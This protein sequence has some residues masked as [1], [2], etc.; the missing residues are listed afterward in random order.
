MRGDVTHH[1]VD[2]SLGLPVK[3]ALAY[4]IEVS[5]PSTHAAEKRGA[6]SGNFLADARRGGARAGLHRVP[7]VHPRAWVGREGAG[8]FLKSPPPSL[9]T[10]ARK[11]ALLWDFMRSVDEGR[12][13]GLRECMCVG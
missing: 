10:W 3:G 2:I 1:R 11:K 13:V 8:T 7:R 12:K 5:S 4:E 9:S 6:A